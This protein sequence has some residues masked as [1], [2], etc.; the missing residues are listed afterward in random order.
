MTWRWSRHPK[1]AVFESGKGSEKPLDSPFRGTEDKQALV[2]SMGSNKIKL[3]H[4]RRAQCLPSHQTG[5]YW[6]VISLH[7]GKGDLGV[8]WG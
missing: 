7:P 4:L 5:G 6:E 1:A 2:L 8:G 3:G